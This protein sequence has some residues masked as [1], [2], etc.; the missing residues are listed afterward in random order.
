MPLSIQSDNAGD[1]MK[2]VSP[3]RREDDFK[4]TYEVKCLWVQICRFV[5]NL[6][7]NEEITDK[8]IFESLLADKNWEVISSSLYKDAHYGKLLLA[9]MSAMLN[10]E[11]WEKLTKN[12]LENKLNRS[13]DMAGIFEVEVAYYR[14]IDS[15]EAMN[16]TL[17]GFNKNRNPDYK[18]QGDPGDYTGDPLPS[19]HSS[20]LSLPTELFPSN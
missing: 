3:I 2:Y 6:F 18:G 5:Y 1:Y 14:A 10:Q 13:F 20:Q 16:Y 12:E 15:R 19:I 17:N 7:N 9:S 4:Y 8:K 11:G